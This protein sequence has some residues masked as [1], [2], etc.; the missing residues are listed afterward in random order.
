MP[1]TLQEIKTKEESFRKQLIIDLKEAIDSKISDSIGIRSF[2]S[3]II[4]VPTRELL[5][6][7]NYFEQLQNDYQG[8]NLKLNY[9][10]LQVSWDTSS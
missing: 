2:F 8:I 5:K 7:N 9:G 4:D 3:I 10:N 6:Q 1:Y